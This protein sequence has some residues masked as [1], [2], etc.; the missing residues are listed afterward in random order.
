MPWEKQQDFDGLIA[1]K[2][3]QETYF[4]INGGFHRKLLDAYADSLKYVNRLYNRKYG[5]VARKVPAHC[6]HMIDIN[7]MAELQAMLVLNSTQM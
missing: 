1:E 2:L 5:Y 4:K 3:S 6:P 7:H